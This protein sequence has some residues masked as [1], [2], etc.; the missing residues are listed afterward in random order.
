MM[1][2]AKPTALPPADFGH[3][4]F[5]PVSRPHAFLLQKGMI[6][7]CIESYPGNVRNIVSPR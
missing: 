5:S 3:L 6:L 7:A 4:L 2:A 1:S